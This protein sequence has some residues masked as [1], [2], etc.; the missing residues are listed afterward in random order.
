MS[1][2]PKYGRLVRRTAPAGYDAPETQDAQPE[3]LAVE[4]SAE[5]AA[6]AE[7]EQVEITAQ[8]ADVTDPGPIIPDDWRELSW[9][10]L[11][12]LAAG[13][14]PDDAPVKTKADAIARIEAELQARAQ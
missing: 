4:E 6:P 3:T 12:S 13:L 9:P 7:V 8:G 5:T 11:R 14:S 10:N 2:I 1:W